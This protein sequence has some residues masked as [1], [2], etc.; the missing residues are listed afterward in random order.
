MFRHTAALIIA[1]SLLLSACGT[2]E[3]KTSDNSAPANES[4]TTVQ[5]EQGNSNPAETGKPGS[6]VPEPSTEDSTANEENLNLLRRFLQKR[7]W[8]RRII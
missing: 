8:K 2:A 4:T 6:G 3:E 1:A 7:K 5:E